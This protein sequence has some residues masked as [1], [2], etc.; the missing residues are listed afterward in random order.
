MAY[1]LRNEWERKVPAFSKKSQVDLLV[2]HLVE[3]TVA[4]G[5]HS[6]TRSSHNNLNK[7]NKNLKKVFLHF[8]AVKCCRILTLF[9]L[10][11]TK[12]FRY[13][14]KTLMSFSAL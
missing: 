12:G 8:V 6:H 4:K 5:T 1:W 11:F 9:L 7:Q 13:V 2:K 3:S 14:F 10:D